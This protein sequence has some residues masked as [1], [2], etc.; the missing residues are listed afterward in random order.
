MT[1]FAIM[2]TEHTSR[3]E[4]KRLNN[5]LGRAT[6]KAREEWRSAQ[7][8]EELVKEGKEDQV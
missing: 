1:I 6:D 4:Y 5:E 7:C 2:K 3:N 8:N